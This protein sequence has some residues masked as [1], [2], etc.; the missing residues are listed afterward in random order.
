MDAEVVLWNDPEVLNGSRSHE[1]DGYCLA[2]GF[3]YEDRSRSG[4]IAAQ[5][6]IMDIIK[7]EAKKGKVVIGICNGAQIIVESGLIPGF[8]NYDLSA[9]LAW[10]EMSVDGVVIDTGFRNSWAYLKNIAP[11]NRSAF[12]DF[13]GLLHIPYAH[14]EGRFVF[15]DP[16][17]LEN[18]KRNGQVLFKYCDEKGDVSPNFPIT[19]NGSTEAIAAICNPE[20]NV[21]AIM[22]HP[23]RDPRGNGN[24]VFQSINKWV[25]TNAKANHMSLGEHHT[26]EDVRDLAPADL[27]FLVRL[28]IVDNSERTVETTLRKKSFDIDLKRYIYWSVKLAKGQDKKE[29]A[30]K[31]IKSGELANL[32]KEWIYVRFD[33][34]MYSYNKEKGL[35]EAELNIKNYLIACD[36]KDFVGESKKQAIN[37][38]SGNIIESITNG[39][40]WEV[41]RIDDDGIYKLIRTKILYN[42]NSMYILKDGRA[43]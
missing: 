29:A 12:N 23:E 8:D 26:K 22:P 34:Q 20:G 40:F 11:K 1:F 37:L 31:I 33:G 18:L 3:S 10:N 27:E 13:E 41:K 17:V 15:K 36:I 32:N 5:N 21:M 4:V 6:P 42:P 16:E 24:M 38:H 19:P 43:F 30:L 35:Q 9:A 25:E 7:K 39:V 14:G 2:G 28:I